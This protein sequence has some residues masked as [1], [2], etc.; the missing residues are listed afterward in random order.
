MC[1]LNVW[2]WAHV[3]ECWSLPIKGHT[4]T[5]H[6]EVFT[7][8]YDNAFLPNWLLQGM[9]YI[10]HRSCVSIPDLFLFFLCVFVK[11]IIW[12]ELCLLRLLLDCDSDWFHS[13][14]NKQMPMKRVCF[15]IVLQHVKVIW[16]SDCFTV[17]CVQKFSVCLYVCIALRWCSAKVCVLHGPIFTTLHYSIQP[18]FIFGTWRFVTPQ[19]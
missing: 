9:F 10:I 5:F 15:W 2:V 14:W 18:C 4:V 7:I 19:N 3:T 1:V 8:L 11:M 6:C 12:R 16:L 13:N 17:K